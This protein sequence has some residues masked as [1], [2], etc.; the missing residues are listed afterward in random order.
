MDISGRIRAVVERGGEKRSRVELSKHLV[1]V[2]KGDGGADWLWQCWMEV[3]QGEWWDGLW[4]RAF[5]GQRREGY[6]Y[7]LG[8]ETLLDSF[9]Y[10]EFRAIH[11]AYN[12]AKMVG[13]ME[14]MERVQRA[15][16]WHVA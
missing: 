13:K 15:V 16:R 9:V 6:L 7:R 10:E 8:A 11:A 12:I 3:L 2:R 14:M 5:A 4:E 1:E